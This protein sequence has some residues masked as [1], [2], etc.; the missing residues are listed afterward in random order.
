M[1][2]AA[3]AGALCGGCASTAWRSRAQDAKDVFTCAVGLGLGVRARVG[4]IQ[5][6]L[7]V[8]SDYAGLRAGE[9]FASPQREDFWTYVSEAGH[10]I[11]QP[12]PVYV[13]DYDVLYSGYEVFDPGGRAAERHKAEST[14]GMGLATVVSD[15]RNRAYYT[16]VEGVVGAV[17]SLRLAVNPGELADLL[18]GFAGWDVM[19]DDVEEGV[20]R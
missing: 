8:Q 3:F 16:N 1:V 2:A 6:P 14:L 9:W 5:A 4:P 20:R 13:S 17:V 10:V 12:L 7:L 15:R 18:L 19:G 11:D